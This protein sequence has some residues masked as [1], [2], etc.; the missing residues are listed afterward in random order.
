MSLNLQCSLEEVDG[1]QVLRLVGRL[2]TI[3]SPLLDQQ[4]QKVCQKAPCRLV[5]N[6]DQIEYLSSAGMRVVLSAAKKLQASGGHLALAQVQEQVMDLIR[7]AGFD[8]ILTIAGTEG[9]AIQ[10]VQG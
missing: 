5:L 9:E 3:T 2:D 8:T 10:K 4:I 6:F 7:M 1:V